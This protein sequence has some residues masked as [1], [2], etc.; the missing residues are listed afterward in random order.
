M[1]LN[2]GTNIKRL[3]LEKGL[4]QE[5]L[6]GLLSISTAAVSKWEAQNT[7]PDITMLFPLAEIFG[8]SIDDLLGYDEAK[9]K[10]DIDQLLAE[11]K[12]LRID[13]RFTQAEK[14]ICAA[15]KKYPHDYRVMTAYMWDKAGGTAGNYASTLLEN[16]E[17]LTQICNCILDGCTQ[18]DLRAEA[19]NMKAKLL[20][21]NGDT[22]GALDVLSRLP[23]YQSQILKEQLFGKN[24]PEYRYWNRRNCYGL[25][26]VMAFRLA[27]T[28]RF[29]PALS[30]EKKI[31]RLERMGQAFSEMGD[32]PDLEFFCIGEQAIYAT[33]SGMLTADNAPIEDTIRLREKQID[34]MQKMRGLAQ[35]DEVLKESIERTYGTDDMVAWLVNR[36]LYSPHDQFT[37][38][39]E[40]PEYTQMLMKYQEQ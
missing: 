2:I 39:R 6:A 35:T 40:Y 27:R 10:A 12:R 29:D 38:L 21:A 26:D 30:V 20:H 23:E 1:E 34:S 15:R 37:K 4:T 13:G 31:E 8:I 24:T 25:M 17:E 28:V 19:I 9:A 7:Y 32:M 11:Y 33:A 18:D 5:Q 22:Q 3:R 14:M 16:Q 36:L